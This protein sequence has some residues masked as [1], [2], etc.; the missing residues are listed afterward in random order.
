MRRL[1]ENTVKKHFPLPYIPT[2]LEDL[3]GGHFYTTL[4]LKSAF[5]SVGL[6]ERAKERSA[7]IT[8]SGIYLPQKMLMGLANCPSHFSHV[9]SEVTK[10]L[11]YCRAYIDDLVIKTESKDP[12][13]HFEHIQATMRRL[14]EANLRINV[15][16]GT[17]FAKEI[18]FANQRPQRN[19]LC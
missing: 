5:Y 15:L 18:S 14:H 19:L 13:V 1:N 9:I 12:R 17:F 4:D 8:A 7:I 10:D 6:T 11:P 3:R 16:K 2:L